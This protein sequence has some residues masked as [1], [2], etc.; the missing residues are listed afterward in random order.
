MKRI[1]IPVLAAAAL[2]AS[3]S[4]WTDPQNKDFLPQVVQDDPAT[5]ASI[6]DFKASEHPVTMMHVN[7]LQSAPNRRNQHPMALPD[8]VDFLLLN[9]LENLHPTLV[10]EIAEVRSAKSTRTLG[11][12]DYLTIR[13]R[14]EALRDEAVEN[15]G[16]AEF[17]EEQFAEYCAAETEKL[18]AA[19]EE[20]ALDGVVASYLG[21]YDSSAAKPFVLAI[22]AWA[23]QHPER[24]IFFRG[25]PA[26]VVGIEG[27]QLMA[28]C[29]YLIILTETAQSSVAISRL[30]R[31]QLADGVS[32]DRIILE[33]SVPALAD[34]G[35]DAQ[36]GAT[37]QVAAEWVV[38]PKTA[39]TVKCDKR[40][41]A[42][43]NAQEDYF[44]KPTFKRIREA[45]AI[46]NP[47]AADTNPE[48]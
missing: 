48:N 13:S 31:D 3:C 2:M 20:Y 26:F 16:G 21:G 38:D 19:C 39:S 14:W 30:V 8:S 40:G 36:V 5:L 37:V 32:S 9:G 6:R 28:H 41:L 24:L 10:A 45:L 42:V 1:F 15:G 34:G 35:E 47:A 33:A 17:T 27:Q 46:L 12:I 23:R 25:Y 7:G 18:L 43:S 29:R 22:D 11:V 44:N 4:D